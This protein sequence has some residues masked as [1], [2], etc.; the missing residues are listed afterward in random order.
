[1][2]QNSMKHFIDVRTLRDP[3]VKMRQTLDVLWFLRKDQTIS[4]TRLK[5][6]ILKYIENKDWASS[7]KSIFRMLTILL[8]SQINKVQLT[9]SLS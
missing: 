2:P 6:S 7:S 1:M 5:T 4:D 3:T 9:S 8:R